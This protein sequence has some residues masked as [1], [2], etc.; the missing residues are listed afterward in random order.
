MD[1]FVR[2]AALTRTLEWN[3]FQR[4]TR[5]SVYDATLAATV[6]YESAGAAAGTFYGVFQI[7]LERCLI[8]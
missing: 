7:T 6:Q 2:N 1:L 5:F 3:N 4:F 8:D